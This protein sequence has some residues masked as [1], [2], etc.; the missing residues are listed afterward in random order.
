VG[1]GVVGGRIF[2]YGV[3]FG[4]ITKVDC[5][6]AVTMHLHRNITGFVCRKNLLEE[7]AAD[8]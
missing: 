8:A 6:C 1:G 2:M 5:R 4:A 7:N 3:H